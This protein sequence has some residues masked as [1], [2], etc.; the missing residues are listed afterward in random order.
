M[1]MS[2]VPVS[3]D[4]KGASR[5][6]IE[7]WKQKM[8]EQYTPTGDIE[9]LDTTASKIVLR[10]ID[11]PLARL[12]PYRNS[13][14]AWTLERE[15]H[16]GEQY[17]LMLKNSFFWDAETKF[18]LVYKNQEFTVI[19]SGGVCF[20]TQ[21]HTNDDGKDETIIQAADGREYSVVSYYGSKSDAPVIESL[22]ELATTVVRENTNM[23]WF[24][25][26]FLLHNLELV[27]EQGQVV[28]SVG[29]VPCSAR[30]WNILG[31]LNFGPRLSITVRIADSS[32]PNEV[33]LFLGAMT[34][35]N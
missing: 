10:R 13:A 9:S 31:S 7:D 35:Q 21:T 4:F 11:S 24:S 19:D 22:G 20:G 29:D 25:K 27:D 3:E 8:I 26:R 12:A 14:L 33:T 32:V 28:L 18:D 15:G 34:L 17:L 23:K 30:L 5:K 2:K 16:K 6:R 1:E